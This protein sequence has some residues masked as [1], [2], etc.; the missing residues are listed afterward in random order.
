MEYKNA[1]ENIFNSSYLIEYEKNSSGPKKPYERNAETLVKLA[2]DIKNYENILEIGCGTGNSTIVIL[3]SNPNVE[4][5]VAL[6]PSTAFLEVARYKFGQVQKISAFD[7]NQNTL[8]KTFIEYQRSRGKQLSERVN[9]VQARADGGRLPLRD[10]SFDI[11][12]A[13]SVMHWLAFESIDSVSSEYIGKA[14]TDFS[15]ILKPNGRLIFDSSGLQFNFAEDTFNGRAINSFNWLNHSFHLRFLENLNSI[16]MNKNLIPK[17]YTDFSN[18]D[19][20]YHIFD[21][22]F[23]I[24]L[25]SKNGLHILPQSNE[26]PYNLVVDPYDFESVKERVISG[27]RMRYFN[28]AEL[29]NLPDQIKNLLINQASQLTLD[30]YDSSQAEDAASTTAAFVFVKN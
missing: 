19:K 4:N 12:F 8:I 21:L 23:L 30:S 11:I 6:E 26:R 7:R 29:K 2:G 28:S 13:S 20:T 10:N 9:F 5:M 18:F 25:S 24:S 1:T 3:E 27:A 14:F 22:N 17:P 15:R 16:L